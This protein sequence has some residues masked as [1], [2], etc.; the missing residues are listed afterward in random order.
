MSH[1]LTT[2]ADGRVEFAYLA[3]DGTPWH[4]LGQ[5]LDD[6]TS[7]DAWREAAAECGIAPVAGFNGGDNAGCAYFQ[8]NQRRGRRWS[9]A[10][11]SSA[12]GSPIPPAP[13]RAPSATSI[14]AR[15]ERWRKLPLAIRVPTSRSCSICRRR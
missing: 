1:E 10:R 4:G 5:A 2:R 12:T 8:M 9:A 6:G 7:L 13:T 14:P 11:S 15:Y 3:S